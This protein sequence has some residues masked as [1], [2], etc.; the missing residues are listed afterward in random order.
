[1]F[2]LK[3]IPSTRTDSEFVSTSNKLQKCDPWDRYVLQRR[4]VDEQ[5]NKWTNKPN[6]YLYSS[7]KDHILTLSPF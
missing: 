2:V 6:E 5:A 4:Q 1:M 7:S 3:D